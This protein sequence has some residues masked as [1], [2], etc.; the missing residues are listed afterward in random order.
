ML[1]SEDSGFELLYWYLYWRQG[2]LV[3]PT[4]QLLVIRTV[5]Q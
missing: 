2:T 1:K 3:V 4:T 5:W